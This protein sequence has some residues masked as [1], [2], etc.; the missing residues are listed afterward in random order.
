MI[1][2]LSST[3]SILEFCSRIPGC[4]DSFSMFSAANSALRMTFFLPVGRSP[5]TIGELVKSAPAEFVQPFVV[6]TEVVGDLVHNRYGHLLDHVVVGF[7]DGQDR[8]AV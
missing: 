2:P 3:F 8:V 5:V 4:S 7:A 1:S 6:D